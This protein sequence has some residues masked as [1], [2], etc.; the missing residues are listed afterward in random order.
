MQIAYKPIRNLIIFMLTASVLYY[1]FN[2]WG[3]RMDSSI[4][5]GYIQFDKSEIEGRLE[6][7][8]IRYHMTSF[9][10][11]GDNHEYIVSPYTDNDYGHIFNGIAKPGD[12]IIKA[13]YSKTF[14]LKKGTKK[15]VF[16]FRNLLK[17]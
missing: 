15:Y 8:G 5:E 7:T 3:D 14:T 1:L 13:A 6:R 2:K 4:K 10:L 17:D 16:P 12:S 9:K 11:Q